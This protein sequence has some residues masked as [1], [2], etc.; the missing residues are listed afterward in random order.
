MQMITIDELKT[1][2][3]RSPGWSVSLFMPAFRRGGETEQNAIRFKNLLREAEEGLLAKGLRAPA[4]R[5]MLAPAQRLLPHPDY[6]QHQSDGLALFLSADSFRA[7]RLPV[8]FEELVVISNRFHLAPLLP[9]F[10]SDGHFYILAISQKQV[11]LMEGT[12]H[13]VDELDTEETFPGMAEALQYEHIDKQLQYHSGA[14]GGNLSPIFHGH[15][16]SDE[17]KNKRLRWFRKINEALPAALAGGTSPLVL[18]GVDY[19]FPLYREANT[20][21][22]LME[23]GIPG[24]PDDLRPDE[25]HARAWPLVEPVFSKAREKAAAQ[26]VRSAGTGQATTDVRVA[27]PAAHHGRVAALFV[28]TGVR[29][30][31]RFD[32]AANS[33]QI[34]ESPEPDDEDLLD[35]T[36]IQTILNGGTVYAVERDLVPERASLAAVFRY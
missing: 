8:P 11:R 14:P 16:I 4:V 28:A 12:R 3:A 32:E 9:L 27:V 34:H 33:V 20:Y 30:W 5:E 10:T 25:L 15:E 1:L 2:L 22:H 21:P 23:E 26:F 19:L 29:I 13:T 18:A 31:G 17:E 36:A 6:W 35:L 7:Y 24:S